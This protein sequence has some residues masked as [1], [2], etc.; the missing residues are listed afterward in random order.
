VKEWIFVSDCGE[1]LSRIL[2]DGNIGEAYNMR[3]N[4]KK[5][6]WMLLRCIL[7][8]LGKPEELIEFTKDRLGHDFRYSLNS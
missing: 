1:A 4:R 2:V 7:K 6:T 3:G 5:E 8:L